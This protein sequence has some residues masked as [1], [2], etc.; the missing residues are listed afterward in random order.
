MSCQINHCHAYVQMEKV[1]MGLDSTFAKTLRYEPEETADVCF[2][3]SV[4]E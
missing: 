2:R 4:C 1:E 3:F